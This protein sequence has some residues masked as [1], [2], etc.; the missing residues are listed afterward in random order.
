M[1]PSSM[2]VAIEAFVLRGTMMNDNRTYFIFPVHHL[3]YFLGYFI[4]DPELKEQSREVQF[5]KDCAKAYELGQRL[6]GK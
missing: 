2:G 3:Q 6:S 5:P 4:I 1:I